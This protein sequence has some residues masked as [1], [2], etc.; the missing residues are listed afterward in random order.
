MDIKEPL[1]DTFLA[2][3]EFFN[4]ARAMNTNFLSFERTKMFQDNKKYSTNLV[5][6]IEDYGAELIT[7]NTKYIEK[8]ALV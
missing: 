6:L 4:V 3:V 5:N 2:Y 7:L 8:I 1:R